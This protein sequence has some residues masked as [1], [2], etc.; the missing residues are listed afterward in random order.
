[1]VVKKSAY[2][3]EFSPKA[4]RQFKKL[5]RAIQL[6]LGP[7]IDSLAENPRPVGVK[8]LQGKD[9]F[10]RIRA[11]DYRIIYKIQDEILT[12]LVLTI[13]HRAAVYR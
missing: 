11:G 9:D 5:P 7:K 8:K 1:M 4:D 6:R 10:Y 13:G 3:I 2:R 12:V